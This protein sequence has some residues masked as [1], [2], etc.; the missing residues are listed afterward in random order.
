M[1]SGFMLSKRRKEEQALDRKW[2]NAILKRDSYTCRICGAE[3]T[4][5]HHIF[6]RKHKNTRW[7]IQNGITLCYKHHRFAHEHPIAF[8]ETIKG[9]INLEELHRL[10]FIPIYNQELVANIP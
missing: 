10:A 7:D 9:E 2:S 3:G 5:P 8:W 6:S 4:N 1:Y